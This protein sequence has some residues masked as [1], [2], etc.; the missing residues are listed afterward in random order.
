MIFSWVAFN[1]D[2]ERFW[3]IHPYTLSSKNMLDLA[4]SNSKGKSSECTM[5][6]CMTITANNGSTRQCET[7]FWSNYMNYTLLWTINIIDSYPKFFAVSC[8]RFQLHLRYTINH[9]KCSIF[10][11]YIMVHRRNC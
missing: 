9:G 10:S 5:R 2:Q 4:S 3:F 1:F 6:R 8:Q 11:R 7:K